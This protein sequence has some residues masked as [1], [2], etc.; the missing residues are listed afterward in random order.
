MGFPSIEILSNNGDLI[1]PLPC[2]VML[3]PILPFY[4]TIYQLFV[5]FTRSVPLLATFSSSSP[6]Q[7]VP[8]SIFG[9]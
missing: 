7:V 8:S 9:C 2:D 6:G 4:V 5:L 3:W 1:G